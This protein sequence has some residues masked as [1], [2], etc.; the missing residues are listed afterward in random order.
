M[1]CPNCGTELPDDA[2]FCTDCGSQLQAAQEQQPAQPDDGEPVLTVK[3]VFIPWLTVAQILPI[4][5]FLTIWAGGF[6]GGFSLAGIKLLD[7][8]IPS[9]AP[10]VFWGGLVFVSL[11]FLG[12]LI[13]KHTYDLTEY[14]FYRDRLEYK[15]G[16]LEAESK[17]VR[18]DNVV[19][20]SMKRGIIQKRYNLGTIHLKTPG[21]GGGDDNTGRSSGIKLANIPEPERVYETI[22]DLAGV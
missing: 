4:Q 21:G 22:Q 2:S 1:F 13:R 14:T 6:L 8:N 20:A 18:Y 16:F 19:E 17:R 3:P 11:P 9:W 10:F 15:E 7:L 12:Y 5:I